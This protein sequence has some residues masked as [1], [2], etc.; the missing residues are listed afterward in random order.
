M[1][2]KFTPEVESKLQYYVYAL[3]DPRTDQIFYVGKG[4]GNRVFQHIAD[5]ENK[6]AYSTSEKLDQIRAIHAT[7]G[8]TY[9]CARFSV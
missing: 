5:A 9:R 4:V 2:N 7:L 1:D 8:C 6:N 3:V